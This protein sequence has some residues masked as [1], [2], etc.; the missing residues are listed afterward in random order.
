MNKDFMYLGNKGYAQYYNKQDYLINLETDTVTRNI[1]NETVWTCVDI[2][3]KPRTKG[4]GMDI[5]KRSPIV[6]IFNNP[7]YGKQYC[8]LEDKTGKPYKNIYEE[9]MPLVCGKFQL[10]SYYDKVKAIDITAKN[11]RKAD[12]TR[13]YGASTAN[14]ILQGRI[15]VG[16]TKNMCRDSWGEPDDINKTIT[17]YGTTEQ[18]VLWLQ[19]CVFRRKRSNNYNPKLR[20]YINKD[21]KKELN[22]LLDS[23][24]K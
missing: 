3:V 20:I 11:K 8:Y 10:K 14:L 5:D 23:D 4:D 15:R 9:E 12:L 6:L 16:M 22:K 13:K 1:A 18:W 17:T 2:Q 19:L 24:L 7:Q 21:Q